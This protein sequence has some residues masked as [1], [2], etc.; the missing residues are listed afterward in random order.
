MK[1]FIAILLL[2]AFAGLPV[3]AREKEKP[4]EKAQSEVQQRTGAEVIWQQND[5]ARN[6]ADAV[7]RKLL[8]KPLTVASSVQIA[9][10]NNRDIQATFEEIGIARADVIEAV[11]LPNPTVDFEVQFPV[12]N[13]PFNRY[14]WVVAQEFVQVLMIPLKKRVATEALEA[15]ELRVAAQVLELVANVKKAYFEVQADQQL[16][17]R[18]KIIQ[19]TNAT[20]LDLAQKQFKAGN[21]TDLAL[22]Q[23]QSGYSEGRLQI[24]E[25]Q[26]DLEEHIEDLNELLG[27]WGQQTD[28]EIRGDLPAA[29]QDPISMRRLE[30]LAVGQRLDLRSAQREV[31]SLASAL[32]LTK[33]FRWVPVLDFGFSGE[34]DIDPAL[35][36]G[37]QF[38]IELPIFNQGQSRVARGQARLRQA[39][40]KYEALAVDIRSNVR[41][42]R[43]TLMRLQDRAA[44]YHDDLLPTRL[45]I[46]NRSILQYN[47]MQI[48]PFDLFQAKAS[49]LSAER[50]YIETLRD[51]WITRAKLE[52]AVGGT[53]TPPKTVSSDKQVV[54]ST[55]KQKNHE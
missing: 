18:L 37:P 34:K 40:A 17:A 55:A 51:Y 45:N 24:A 36:M 16:L 33:T 9:L 43:G 32:G 47:A 26:T 41:K 27:L 31:S 5:A 35:N 52:Q 1:N 23:M 54:T 20:S 39:A 38:R 49:E 10:L 3:Y 7:V 19:E 28:W 22:L 14:G 12:W 25:A 15:A 6:E 42:Y 29:G 11:T 53:L 30:S 50:G 2:A 44:F 21:I 48:S 46:V 4:D 13:T 8:A